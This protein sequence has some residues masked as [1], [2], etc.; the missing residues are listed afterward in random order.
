MEGL[1]ICGPDPQQYEEVQPKLSLQNI[2][3]FARRRVNKT[4]LKQQLLS[5]DPGFINPKDY[6]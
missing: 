2:I 1:W 4:M 5:I 6:V 3:V